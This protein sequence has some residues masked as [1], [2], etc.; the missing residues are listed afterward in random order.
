MQMSVDVIQINL[1]EE[2]KSSGGKF[3][4]LSVVNLTLNLGAQYSLA[5]AYLHTSIFMSLQQIFEL[6]KFIGIGRD[7][8]LI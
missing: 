5:Q 4:I 6:S 7:P 3:E 2:S 8:H 1:K